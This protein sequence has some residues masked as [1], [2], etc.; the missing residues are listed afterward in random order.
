MYI[1]LLAD[2]LEESFMCLPFILFHLLRTVCSFYLQF[3][4][5][6]IWVFCWDCKFLICWSINALSSVYID[7]KGFLLSYRLSFSQQKI[8]LRRRFSS[9]AELHLPVVGIVPWVIS[10]L[11]AALTCAY[12]LQASLLFSLNCFRV[13]GLTLRALFFDAS[14]KWKVGISS[15]CWTCDCPVFW[16]WFVKEVV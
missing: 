5:W 9:C 14:E 16:P 7:S 15:H 10:A 6:V 8:L 4:D 12:I 13:S 11:P 2:E 3:I 1:S